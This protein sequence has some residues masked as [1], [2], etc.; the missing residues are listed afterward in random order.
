MKICYLY[1]FLFLLFSLN[2]V[3]QQL[4]ETE[5]LAGGKL[6]S[7]LAIDD[8]FFA[9]TVDGV[10]KSTDLGETWSIVFELPTDKFYEHDNRITSNL[11]AN[12]EILFLNRINDLN[13]VQEQLFYSFNK[14][15]SWSELDLPIN[16]PTYINSIWINEHYL[17]IKNDEYRFFD[18][19]NSS[20]GILDIPNLQNKKIHVSDSHLFVYNKDSIFHTNNTSNWQYKSAPF[21]T[22]FNSTNRA[23]AVIGEDLYYLKNKNIY[24]SALTDTAYTAVDT[25]RQTIS[26]YAKDEYLYFSYNGFLNNDYYLREFNTDNQVLTVFDSLDFRDNHKLYLSDN[27]GIRIIGYNFFPPDIHADFY[28]PNHVFP[29]FSNEPNSIHEIHNSFNRDYTHNL[30][31]VNNIL[32]NCNHRGLWKLDENANQWSFVQTPFREVYD[33]I[34]HNGDYYISDG[35]FLIKTTDF[36][37]YE[38]VNGHYGAGEHMISYD[39]KLMLFDNLYLSITEDNGQTWTINKH[40]LLNEDGTY[41]GINE[42][43]EKPIIKNDTLFFVSDDGIVSSPDFG[44]TFEEMFGFQER[45]YAHLN[46]DGIYHLNCSYISTDENIRVHFEKAPYY[47]GIFFPDNFIFEVNHVGNSNAVEWFRAFLKSGPALFFSLPYFGII[48]SLDDGLSWE[49]LDNSTPAIFTTDMAQTAEYIYFASK[50]Y[51]VRRLKKDLILDNKEVSNYEKQAFFPNPSK[52][53]FYSNQPIEGALYA[54]NG[55]LLQT[56][57]GVSTIDLKNVPS[58][59][60]ILKL[61]NGQVE[62]LVKK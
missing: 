58:G 57:S 1:I 8:D 55:Q 25:S 13:P 44:Y 20:W 37:N 29:R 45:K 61:K 2:L 12:K 26:L 62:L 5:G 52:Q 56:L 11:Y 27:Y 6:Y 21:D 51:G 28:Q 39:N 9:V 60:Y 16:S 40:L 7:M 10:V 32:Y 38:D 42:F 35:G 18:F 53:F 24:K 4:E 43:F 31:V 47:T 33:I 49:I 34:F 19:S 30:R 3:G 36:I 54:T 17:F 59:M 48:Y 23:L 41:P 14:G 22:L 46:T 15:D 50:Q